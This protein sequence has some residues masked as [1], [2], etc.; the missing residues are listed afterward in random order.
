[1]ETNIKE[2]LKMMIDL[3]N[4]HYADY[5]KILFTPEKFEMIIKQQEKLEVEI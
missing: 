3:N 4:A 1:M 5:Q 2:L